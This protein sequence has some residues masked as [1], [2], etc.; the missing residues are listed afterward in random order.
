MRLNSSCDH[1]FIS[2]ISLDSVKPRK[3]LFKAIFFLQL[4]N[5]LTM[6]FFLYEERQNATLCT[7]HLIKRKISQLQQF[8]KFCKHRKYVQT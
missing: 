4:S 5:Y 2:F 3:N 1:L 6:V 8:Y 7:F